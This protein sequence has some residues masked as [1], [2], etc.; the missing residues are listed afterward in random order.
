MFKS[1]DSV[2]SILNIHL[3]M[4]KLSAKRV[5]CLSLIDHKHNVMTTTNDCV[6]L[7]HSNSNTFLANFIAVDMDSPKHTEEQAAVESMGFHGRIRGEEGQRGSKNWRNV[8]HSVWSPKR[9]R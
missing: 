6:G 1:H 9:L 8:A 2:I 7:F 5:S 3:G 4:R